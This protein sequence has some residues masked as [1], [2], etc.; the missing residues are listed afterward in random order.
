MLS[1]YP[2]STAIPV[3]DLDRAR[4]WYEEKLGFVP[5]A[6]PPLPHGDGGIF[7]DAGDGT[8]FYLYPTYASA[9]AGHTI[10]EFLVG[11]DLDDVMDELRARGITFKEYDYPDLATHDGVAEFTGPQAHRAAW[12]EDSEGNILALGSYARRSP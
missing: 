5:A 8:S 2:L 12:F 11:D 1:A 10:A 7:F 9:G 3:S 4:A 6:D